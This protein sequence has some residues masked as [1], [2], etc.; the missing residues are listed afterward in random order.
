MWSGPIAVNP[1]G[2]D[3]RDWIMRAG[4][5]IGSTVVVL[6]LIFRVESSVR[7][8]FSS[9]FALRPDV[10]SIADIITGFRNVHII[11][12]ALVMG[13]S[14]WFRRILCKRHTPDTRKVHVL[15]T[16]TVTVRPLHDWE[17]DGQ[18]S[19]DPAATEL[20][21]AVRAVGV[22]GV[23]LALLRQLAEEKHIPSDWPMSRVCAEVVKPVTQYEH[24][25][26]R[27]HCAYAALVGK[28]MD[29]DGRPLVAVATRFVSYCWQYPWRVVLSALEAFEQQQAEPS[30]F[31]IDQLCL[32]QHTMAETAHDEQDSAYSLIVDRLQ[33]SIEVP[34]SLSYAF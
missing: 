9:A 2:W 7:H 1:D 14:A 30:Y 22:L 20:V 33:K 23:S 31:F 34:G 32:D 26:K 24:R 16:T 12:A 17:A 27:V 15:P 19:S 4:F 18:Q 25:G 28:A 29:G 5:I 13:R 21:P 3:D 8:G 11:V 10:Q 6:T